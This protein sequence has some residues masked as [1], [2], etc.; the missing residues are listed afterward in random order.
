M[1]S[2]SSPLALIARVGGD[3]GGAAVRAWYPPEPGG[4]R[5][6]YIGMQAQCK[7]SSQLGGGGTG[8]FGGKGEKALREEAA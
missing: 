2:P 5:P 7:Q 3:A 4:Y 6:D 8:Q 1:F